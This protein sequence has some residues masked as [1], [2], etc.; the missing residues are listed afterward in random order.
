MQGIA[1][2]SGGAVWRLIGVFEKRRSQRSTEAREAAQKGPRA[3]QSARH[4]HASA[5]SGRARTVGECF[6]APHEPS[7]NGC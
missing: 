2:K 7:V 6:S 5:S 1:P 3:N 4:D